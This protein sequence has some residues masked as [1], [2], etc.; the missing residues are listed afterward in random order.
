M[1]RT[2]EAILSDRKIT[3][4]FYIEEVISSEFRIYEAHLSV[5]WGTDSRTPV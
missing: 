5:G 3:K 2:L 1:G 4:G